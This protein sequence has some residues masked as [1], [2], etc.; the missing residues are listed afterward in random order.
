MPRDDIELVFGA[1]A[2]DGFEADE[3]QFWLCDLMTG[4]LDHEHVTQFL[5]FVGGIVP[6]EPSASG[7]TIDET[8]VQLDNCCEP[9][10]H[11][12][13]CALEHKLPCANLPSSPVAT[14]CRRLPSSTSAPPQVH[15]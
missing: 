5:Q 1:M 12:S 2:A 10:D 14:A 8:V 15:V 3:V 4:E 11:N 6:Q 13:T 7:G 9:P